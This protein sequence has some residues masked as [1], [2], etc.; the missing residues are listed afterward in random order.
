V[1]GEVKGAKAAPALLDVLRRGGDKALHK[2]A[3]VSLQRYEAGEI[4]SEVIGQ[5]SALDAEARTAAFSLLASRPAWSLLLLRAIDSGKIE[6][7]AVP[8]DVVNK[9]KLQ[10]QPDIT[11]LWV[12]HWGQSKA[13]T[14]AEMQKQID[15]LAKAVREGSGTPYEGQKLFN[16]ACASCH[17]LFAQGGQIG[18]DL[19]TFKRDDIENMLLNIVNPS[20]EIREGY[21]NFAVETKDGRM[22]SGFLA[23][24]DN[25]VVVLRGNDGENLTLAQDQIAEMKPAGVSLMPEGLLDGL[26]EQQVRDLFAYLRSTQPLVR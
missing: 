17:R 26:S 2:A 25:R 8:Q 10:T 1:L 13:P 12:K 16:A 21:E 4:G 9:I 5:L 7:R 19:T 24:K 11:G 18:P 3:L 22:L 15:H 23:D 20:A 14:T 6:K